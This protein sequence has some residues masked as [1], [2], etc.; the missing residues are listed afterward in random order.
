MNKNP[1]LSWGIYAFLTFIV[2]SLIVATGI[3]K[4]LDYFVT[5][6]LQ[7]L[8]PR[9]FDTPFSIFSLIGVAEITGA[10]LLLILLA[11]RKLRLLAGVLLLFILVGAIEVAGKTFIN[12]PPPPAEFLRTNLSFGFPTHVVAEAAQFFS[13]PSGHSARSAFISG[14]I[15][16]L[17][18]TLNRLTKTQRQLIIISVLTFDFLMF[19]SRVYLGEHWMSDVVGG[20]ILGFSLGFL[21]SYFINLKSSK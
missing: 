14:F 21:T 10:V 20:A 4:P 11:M 2:F 19:F 6:N 1:Y 16:V 18:L 3:L 12:H 17:T 15:I 8:V 7:S 13:Y 5:T 9:I